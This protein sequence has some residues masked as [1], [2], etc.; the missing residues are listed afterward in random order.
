MSTPRASPGSPITPAARAANSHANPYAAL[1]F[2]WVELERQ[3]RIEGRVE[4]LP[5]A[6]SD[7]YFQSRPLQSRLGALASRSERADRQPG[8]AGTTYRDAEAAHG[9]QPVRPP[10]WGGY[11]LI[12]D[13]V[14]FWQGRPPG[15]TTAS[16]IHREPGR[17]WRGSACSPRTGQRR[18]ART[19]RILTTSR[20][21]IVFW[22]KKLEHWVGAYPAAGGA[23]A[24]PGAM[25]RPAFRLR[26]QAPQVTVTVPH[27][28]PAL[29][30]QAYAV[31]PGY[32]PM[33]KASSRSKARQGND[34][35]R[36]RAGRAYAKREP[37]AFGCITRSPTPARRTPTAIQ[38][39]YDV[40]NDF[41][42]P[43]WTRTWC[44][45]APISR[46][47]RRTWRP[48]RPKKI[49][50]ILN[51]IGCVRATPCSTSAAAGAR[52]SSARRR[53]YGARVTGITLSDN[54][55]RAGGERVRAGRAGRPGR[56]PAAG[57]P[58]CRR[59]IRP[60]HQ[61]RHVRARRAE[62]TCASTSARSA[63]CSK[64]TAW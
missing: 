35:R 29:S 9:D 3:V 12:P 57:L 10:H 17:R 56:D 22:E 61:R 64:P 30:A 37:A 38:Y 24:A 54:Q 51:K 1:L 36:Q 32:A 62:A 25:E 53:K 50:H 43:G 58:R 48:R 47:A 34:P 42:A 2:H 33:S 7:A 63:R 39:H 31:Q 4:K 8:S 20:R 40:S 13:R 59:R 28:R 15:C 46:M 27:A 5:D 52:W 55:Y 14:E 18:V 23:A 41:Y 49:D 21:Y 6:E 26:P 19:A 11:R 60:H 16:S 44:I 45:P